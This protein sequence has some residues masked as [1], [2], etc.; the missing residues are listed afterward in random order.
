MRFEVFSNKL[1]YKD[2]AFNFCVANFVHNIDNW[3]YEDFQESDYVYKQWL[4]YINSFTYNIKQE[5]NFVGQIKIEKKISFQEML[6]TTK[7]GNKPPLLQLTLHGRISSEFICTL[8]NTFTF[9][10]SWEKEYEHDPFVLKKIQNLI[11][12]RK[13][14]KIIRSKQS[15]YS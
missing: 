13:L 10:E 2:I 5:I 3:I 12:Y 7:N 9:L 1:M 14:L 4:Q 15:E 8:D 6:Q 11:K